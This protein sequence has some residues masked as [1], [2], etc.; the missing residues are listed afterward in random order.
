MVLALP[1][2]VILQVL[3]LLGLAWIVAGLGVALPDVSYFIS[4]FM[5]LLM[6]VSPIAFRLDMVP[7][8]F[9]FV[10]YGNPVYYLLEVF[11]DCLIAG[12]QPDPRIWGVQ[13][14]LSIGLFVLG[15]AFFR[16]FKSV[17]VDSE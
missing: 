14:A 15:A 17:L 1:I 12:R 2:A 13:A 8:A 9:Q 10:V 3:A 6:F 7:P 16:S 5:F 11:R 4:L